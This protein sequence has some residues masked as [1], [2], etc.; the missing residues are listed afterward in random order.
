MR[1]GRGLEQGAGEVRD[2]AVALR[3]VGELVRLRL[4]ERDQLRHA[5]RSEARVHGEHAGARHDH[6]NRNQRV[7]VVVELCVQAL[8]DHQRRRRGHEQRVAVGRRGGDGLRADAA[9]GAGAVVHHHWLAPFL[10][11]PV[12]DQACSEV[13]ASA[14]RV[15]DDD[16]DGPGRVVLRLGG[17]DERERGAE[18][19]ERRQ[20]LRVGCR[21]HKQ[22]SKRQTSDCEDHG[23]PRCDAKLLG[24]KHT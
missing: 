19:G 1:A 7:R 13:V 5:R 4:R 10:A 22:T 14:G 24:V 23:W 16:A 15:G 3:G 17:R 11:Q 6:R 12:R 20:D 8:V 2:G 9:R 18:Q 21:E